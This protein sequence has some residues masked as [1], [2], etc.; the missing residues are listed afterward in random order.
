MFVM[1]QD[2]IRFVFCVLLWCSFDFLDKKKKAQLEKMVTM[3]LPNR[4]NHGLLVL[5]V[6]HHISVGSN[7][8]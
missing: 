1:I 7:G 5:R 8:D 3:V 4:S 2:C 6:T